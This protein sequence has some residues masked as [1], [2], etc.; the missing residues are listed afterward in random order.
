MRHAA[1]VRLGDETVD[2]P[3][4]SV[5][6][7][8][9]ILTPDGVA[10]ARDIGGALAIAL[11][12]LDRAG[13][14]LTVTRFLHEE[15][16]AATATAREVRDGFER[17]ASALRARYGDGPPSLP[18]LKAVGREVSC[19]ERYPQAWLK[20]MTTTLTGQGPACAAL[21][22]GHDPGMSWLL[23]DLLARRG[24][25]PDVPGLGRA[26][27]VALRGDGRRWE[28][29]WALTS[30]G[31][32]DI[33]EVT[34]K[35]RSKMDTAKVFG[36]FVTAMLT[37]II[38]QYAIRPPA[39]TYWAVVRGGSLAA[40]GVGVL[41]YLMTLFWYDRLLMPPRFWSGR[42]G[43]GSVSLAVMQRPPS[44]ALWVLYQNMQR[45]WRGL[46]VPATY[47][48]AVGLAG[49][50]AARTEPASRAAWIGFAAAGLALAVTAWWGWR[51]RPVL[52]V[53]D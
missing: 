9:G 18:A 31:A 27:L 24:R 1:A 2:A 4:G 45:T 35:I 48:S 5:V 25:L 12:D 29:M 19:Q 34:A 44:S 42:P 50:A 21:I 36:G 43:G 7:P 30:G 52:G 15:T 11:D 49:F 10:E 17:T 40:L 14:A 46:F 23:T 53:Q 38:S 41:L 6:P 28:P 13:Q 22:V 16:N 20:K 51:S 47:A 3:S 33:A 32:G 26:E 39:T 37:F 8:S